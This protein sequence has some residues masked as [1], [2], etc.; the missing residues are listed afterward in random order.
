[1]TDQLVRRLEALEI[2]LTR[3][4]ARIAKALGVTESQ[5]V[6]ARRHNDAFQKVHKRRVRRWR[7][8]QGVV[9]ADLYPFRPRYRALI[10]TSETD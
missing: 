3:L 5:E 4:E 10:K 2:R 7:L 9:G 6:K 1:M 8:S